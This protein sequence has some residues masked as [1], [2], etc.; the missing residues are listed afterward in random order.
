MTCDPHDWIK[1]E[2]DLKLRFKAIMDK[3]NLEFSWSGA[4]AH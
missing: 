4:F 2:H 1:I 3:I